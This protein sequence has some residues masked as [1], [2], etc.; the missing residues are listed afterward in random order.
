MSFCSANH[1]KRLTT[2]S[3]HI[4]ETKLSTVDIAR[5]ISEICR[6][7]KKSEPK[8]LDNYLI[9]KKFMAEHLYKELSERLPL[10]Q[11]GLSFAEKYPDLVNIWDEEKNA[12]LTSNH[13]TVGSN[14]KAWWICKNGHSFK[15]S[16]GQIVKSQNCPHCTKRYSQ[17]INVAIENSFGSARPDLVWSWHPRKNKQT[18]FDVTPHSNKEFWWICSNGHEWLTSPDRRQKYGCPYCSGNK[19]G[20]D[21]NLASIMPEVACEW[22]EN[23]NEGLTPSD[24]TRGS[25]KKVWWRCKVCNYEWQGVVEHRT[26]NRSRCPKC[27]GRTT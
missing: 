19:V 13:F 7:Q 2:P 16:I 26:R 23:K 6:I 10:P 17:G 18:P 1:K 27:S 24:V 5:L 14:H 21:N 15:R 22:H 8:W 11:K 12:P 3:I 4:D 25:H 20:S 9:N